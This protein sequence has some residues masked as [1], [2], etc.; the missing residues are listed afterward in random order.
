MPSEQA[1]RQARER[2]AEIRRKAGSK[3]AM[4]RL[5]AARPGTG[6]FV[7][8]VPGE[9]V[10]AMAALAEEH[11]VGCDEFGDL[12]VV[13]NRGHLF[14]A[15]DYMG[16]CLCD[17][18][19]EEERWRILTPAIP[20]PGAYFIIIDGPVPAAVRDAL[21]GAV[22]AR[23]GD[24]GRGLL[25]D[26]LR[27]VFPELE[28]EPYLRFGLLP[29]DSTYLCRTPGGMLFI[30]TDCDDR[31]DALHSYMWGTPTRKPVTTYV[32][33]APDGTLAEVSCLTS[34][35]G[36]ANNES[37]DDARDAKFIPGADAAALLRTSH[38]LDKVQRI[39]TEHGV[40]MFYGIYE[41]LK[42]ALGGRGGE[43]PA[44][45]LL[46]T[47]VAYRDRE[48]AERRRRA[49]ELAEAGTPRNRPVEPEKPRRTFA[50]MV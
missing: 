19:K 28:S 10:R 37:C 50:E 45:L 15:Y 18:T 30:H 12:H 25:P 35:A 43:V 2:A 1:R 47:A 21:A 16:G 7:P 13:D 26:S 20:S 17:I 11:G 23:L 29:A 41:P 33:F 6:G 44:E 9:S 27:D 40:K 46:E 49:A 38:R 32:V 31:D 39:A 22:A 48:Y 5:T 4:V 42:D 36:F 14:R 8:A 24:E 34:F 3:G